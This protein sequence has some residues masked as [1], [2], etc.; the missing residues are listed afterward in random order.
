MNSTQYR[1][2][3]IIYFFATVLPLTVNFGGA[4]FAASKP[5]FNPTNKTTTIPGRKP[6]Y[7]VIS[8]LEKYFKD[9]KVQPRWKKDL[10]PTILSEADV[11]RYRVIFRLQRE[12]E[13]RTADRIIYSL[14]NPI[15]MGQ[16]LAQRYLHPNKYRSSYRELKAWMDKYADH[17]QARRIYKL[18]LRR[19]G[20]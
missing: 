14:K 7:A 1:L 12:G 13:W 9:S 4:V 10:I 16:I 2:I 17:P 15:L 20:V 5:G 6:P 19:V 3:L 18:A 8:D 11:S